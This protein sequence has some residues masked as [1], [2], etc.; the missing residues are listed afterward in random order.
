MHISKDHL[1]IALQVCIEETPAQKCV[2]VRLYK[3]QNRG[4]ILKGVYFTKLRLECK[5]K[6]RK[7]GLWFGC[8]FW[9]SK[10][11][12]EN[13]RLSIRNSNLTWIVYGAISWNVACKMCNF[14]KS[15]IFIPQICCEVNSFPFAILHLFT[16]GSVFLP[17]SCVNICIGIHSANMRR[18]RFK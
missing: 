1:T 15:D 9:L 13:N 11:S 2:S 8:T 5:T 17:H 14:F 18:S 10:G 12:V 7:E 3:T 4:R 16:V 6:R